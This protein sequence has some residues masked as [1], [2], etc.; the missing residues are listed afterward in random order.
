MVLNLCERLTELGFKQSKID[1]ALWYKQREDGLGYDYFTHHIDDFLITGRNVR[2]YIKD[3]KKSY[4]ITGNESHPFL[5]LGMDINQ[6]KP[7]FYEI[8]SKSYIKQV[9]DRVKEILEITVLKKV[10]TPSIED[11]HP[12]IDNS[13]LS[14]KKGYK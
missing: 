8:G 10:S 12:E 14:N 7:H 3:L 4:T 2:T 13:K 9:S 5:H 1:S 11:F 6:F